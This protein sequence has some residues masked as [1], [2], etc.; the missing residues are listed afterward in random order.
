[1]TDIVERLRQIDAWAYADA[2]EL[3]RLAADEITRLRAAFNAAY[4]RGQ[5]D[6][7]ERAAEV[8]DDLMRRT[9]TPRKR[10]IEDGHRSEQHHQEG[11]FQGCYDAEKDIR[12][13]PIKEAPH[14]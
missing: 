13:L 4:Q 7:R 9:D 12:A 14:E 1:M 3:M 6:M 8:C 5:E 2:P 10:A 11:R